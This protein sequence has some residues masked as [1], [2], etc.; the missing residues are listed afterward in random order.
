MLHDTLAFN[1]AIIRTGPSRLGAT[2]VTDSAA[3]LMLQS[4]FVE[5]HELT[6]II[7]IAIAGFA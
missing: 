7:R 1:E 4:R 6:R 3:K 5:P 2:F